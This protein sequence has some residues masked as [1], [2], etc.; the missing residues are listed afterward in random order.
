ME[1]RNTNR[2][3]VHLRA[4]IISSGKS[5]D[6]LVENLSPRG[7]CLTTYPSASAKDFIPGTSPLLK[8]KLNSGETIDLHCDARWLHSFILPTSA[9]VNTLGLEI[10]NPQQKYTEY[11]NS[12]K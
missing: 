3:K 2:I 5:Y 8:L 9:V 7:I 4:E 1:E 10:I 11:F 6:G 12:L